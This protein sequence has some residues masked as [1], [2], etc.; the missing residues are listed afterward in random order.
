MQDGGKQDENDGDDEDDD[1]DDGN[2]VHDTTEDVGEEEEKEDGNKDKEDNT[3][4]YDDKMMININKNANAY[5]IVPNLRPGASFKLKYV[6][7]FL[8]PN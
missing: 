7:D 3:D 5:R 4:A 8:P 6:T 1:N 2:N